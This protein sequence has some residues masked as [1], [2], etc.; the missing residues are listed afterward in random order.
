[1]ENKTDSMT[2]ILVDSVN[3][4]DELKYAALEVYKDYEIT[5][6]TVTERLGLHR[7]IDAKVMER[8]KKAL[9]DLHML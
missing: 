9:A 1:M 6:A 7:P 8:L 2:A 4:A 3:K 5:R